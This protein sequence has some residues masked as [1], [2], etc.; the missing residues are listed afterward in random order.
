[1]AGWAT[2]WGKIHFCENFKIFNEKIVG[3]KVTKRRIIF[4][5]KC[6]PFCTADIFDIFRGLR[7]FATGMVKK[8]AGVTRASNLG[9][10]A[11]LD[12]SRSDGSALL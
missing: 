10:G 3:S 4:Q 12:L 11:S 1:M 8:R 9:A 2:F 5:K 6:M 7:E